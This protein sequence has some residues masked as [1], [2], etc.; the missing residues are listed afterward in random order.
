M[1]RRTLRDSRYFND[2]NKVGAMMTAG[3]LHRLRQPLPAGSPSDVMVPAIVSLWR[4]I[5]MTKASGAV[6]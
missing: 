6:V 3:R 5:S 1:P 2:D 4:R